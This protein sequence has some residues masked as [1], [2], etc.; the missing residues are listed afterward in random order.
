[1]NIL[2]IL[3]FVFILGLYGIINYYIG[4]RGW[5]FF[6]LHMPFLNNKV[7]WI[8]LWIIAMAFLVAR[9]GHQRL[10][11][12]LSNT[13]L[14]VGSYWW[15]ILTYLIIL[16]LLIDIVRFINKWTNLIPQQHMGGSLITTFAGSFVVI[17][18][19]LIIGFGTWNAKNTQIVNYEVEIS[20]A[21]GHLDSLHIVLVSDLHLGSLVNK[22]SLERM[23][24]SINELNPDLVLIPGDIVDDN[25]EPFVEQDMAQVFKKIK[26]TYGTYASMGNHEYIG[27]QSDS[28]D[29]HLKQGEVTLL[30]DEVIKI[31]DSFY[32]VGRED[33]S[34]ERF[35]KK[36]RK[37]L[38]D[39]LEGI[40]GSLP[41]ILMDHQPSNLN[42]AREQAIDLQVSGHTHRGQ[43]SPFHLITK[44]I[45]EIDRGLLKTDDFH[46]VVTSGYGTWGPPMR[47]GSTSEIVS[48][49]VKFNK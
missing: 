6:S 7:Y 1:V 19:V 4:L 22:K 39:I 27:G 46:I 42:E 28:I 36:P 23:V 47:L 35:A 9:L 40:D 12:P 15:G 25:I 38:E 43:L 33:K 14:R 17:S 41:I 20:K 10:P 37:P 2:M 24:N 34:Y 45:F 8:F 32:I 5:Q 29:E 3:M 13:L 26:S 49:I 11:R 44:K 48:I 21:P 31:A 16:L 18:I 30:R